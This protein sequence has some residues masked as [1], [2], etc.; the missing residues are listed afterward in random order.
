MNVGVVSYKH[1][2][3]FTGY[4]SYKAKWKQVSSAVVILDAM[5][6]LHSNKD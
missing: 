6:I 1:I 3:S 2:E 5:K 4:G